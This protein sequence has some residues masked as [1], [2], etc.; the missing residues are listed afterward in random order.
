MSQGVS[1]EWAPARVV[2]RTVSADDAGKRLTVAVRKPRRGAAR[3]AIAGEGATPGS[4]GERRG[5]R[6]LFRA[7]I[8]A[9]LAHQ[10]ASQHRACHPPDA[11]VATPETEN[12]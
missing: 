11:F 5:D 4:L 8:L 7:Q 6:P 1:L 9:G 12:T 2:F 10:V 3:R